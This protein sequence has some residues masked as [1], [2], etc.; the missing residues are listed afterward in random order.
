MAEITE[1]QIA[2]LAAAPSNVTTDGLSISERPIDEV[3][4]AKEYLDRKAALTGANA[5]GGS[6]SGWGSLRPARVVPPGAI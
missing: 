5:N 3:I 4:D 1:Q 2:D 6:R